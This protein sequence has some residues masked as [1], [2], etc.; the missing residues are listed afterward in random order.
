[1][2]L[3][4]SVALF[5]LAASCSTLRYARHGVRPA[6]TALA[7]SRQRLSAPLRPPMLPVV[8][9]ALVTKKPCWNPDSEPCR[10]CCAQTRQ[11]HEADNAHH[12][13]DP[14]CLFSATQL[15]EE[16]SM[17]STGGRLRNIMSC[18]TRAVDPARPGG[19]AKCEKVPILN[20]RTVSVLMFSPPA[21]ANHSPQQSEARAS[22]RPPRRCPLPPT[23]GA[24]RLHCRQGEAAPAPRRD[25]SGIWGRPS[26]RRRISRMARRTCPMTAST[27]RLTPLGLQTLKSHKPL[28]G[29]AAVLRG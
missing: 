8:L 3:R 10:F 23:V 4:A 11:G 5:P 24:T 27:I 16:P 21:L 26:G 1:M 17:A 20:D 29:Q 22:G 25:L 12:H 13:Q 15:H 14:P 6:P 28:F 2:R 18:P 9:L 7:R 19:T